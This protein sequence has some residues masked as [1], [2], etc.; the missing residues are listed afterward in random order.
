MNYGLACD[1]PRQVGD[2]EAR[3][4]SM[5]T[6]KF[7][8]SPMARACSGHSMEGSIRK[9]FTLARSGSRHIHRNT[10]NMDP[11]M[12]NR[13]DPPQR[14]PQHLPPRRQRDPTNQDEIPAR[15]DP[16][17]GDRPKKPVTRNAN[18]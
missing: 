7:C 2:F 17:R 10:V 4:I 3:S 18:R 14:E 9:P 15:R 1:A 11:D 8:D 5:T 16:E 6:E 13:H 12:R